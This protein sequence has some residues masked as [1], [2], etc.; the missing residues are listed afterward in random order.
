MVGGDTLNV[1]DDETK[2]FI[3]PITEWIVKNKQEKKCLLTAY[4]RANMQRRIDW[5]KHDV[6][7]N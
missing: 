1:D 6:Q 2:P 3:S 5:R 7:K 4:G